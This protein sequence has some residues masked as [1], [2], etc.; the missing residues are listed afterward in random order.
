MFIEV[1]LTSRVGNKRC[2]TLLNVEHIINVIP[3]PEDD[4]ITVVIT[5]MGEVPV[6]EPYVSLTERINGIKSVKFLSRLKAN[7]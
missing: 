6:K 3:L 1:E 2:Y 5:I 7:A 4:N